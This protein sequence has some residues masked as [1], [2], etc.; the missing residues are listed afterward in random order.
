MSSETSMIFRKLYKISDDV[1]DQLKNLIDQVFT[2]PES[3]IS[4][5]RMMKSIDERLQVLKRQRC[6]AYYEANKIPIPSNN[7]IDR[8][9]DDIRRGR[10]A[11]GPCLSNPPSEEELNLE[12]QRILYSPYNESQR[13][14]MIEYNGYNSKA[15]D[16]VSA[17]N[18]GILP[19]SYQD[20]YNT[21]ELV[22]IGTFQDG[23]SGVKPIK[24]YKKKSSRFPVIKN[25]T[26]TTMN[27]FLKNIPAVGG[28]T[29]KQSRK[30]RTPKRNPK[31]K[32]KQTRRR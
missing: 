2:D 5:R 13:K 26:T 23:I 12:V 7:D 32:S 3:I 14:L 4:Y 21:T 1:K 27:N 28:G 20:R 8:Q 19:P 10:N 6:K 11:S 24:G 25:V 18:Y 16:S 15:L 31:R 29:R 9:V 17:Y 30:T 22:T